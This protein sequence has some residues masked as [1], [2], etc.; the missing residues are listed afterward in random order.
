MPEPPL[1]NA[2]FDAM[3]RKKHAATRRTPLVIGN[4]KMHKGVFEALELADEIAALVRTGATDGVR[5]AVAPAYPALYPVSEALAGSGVSVIGQD[6]HPEPEGAFTGAVSAPM[7]MAAGC[8]GVL[9]GHSERRQLFGDTDEAVRAKTLAALESALYPVLCVGETLEEH[10]AGD[11]EAVVERQLEAVVPHL[12]ADG[13]KKLVVAYEPV[14]A[15]GT[16]RSATPEIVDE[17]H[18]FVRLVVA[19]SATPEAA[20]PLPVLYGG[21][22]TGDN[23]AAIMAG[24]HVDG[25]L[26]GGASLRADSFASICR[27]AR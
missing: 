1:S 20:I 10:D 3:W 9:V 7:L 8:Q 2:E 16:G 5:I 24:L 14:W 18:G 11:A 26:V 19:R 12:D 27:A 4:W 17:M 25:V 22:V 23:A 6:V 13:V 15:I 21:S